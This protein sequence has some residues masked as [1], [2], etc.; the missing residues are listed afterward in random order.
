VAALQAAVSRIA[1]SPSM[2]AGDAAAEALV[3]DLAANTARC[4]ASA[5]AHAGGSAAMFS[6]GQSHRTQRT[7]MTST[8]SAS[9]YMTPA[10]LHAL[11]RAGRS[12]S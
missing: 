3:A 8:P 9:M 11:Q 7:T 12:A 2:A 10:Q 6:A 1:A 4:S 5:F